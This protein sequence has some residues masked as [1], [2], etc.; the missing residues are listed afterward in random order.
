LEHSY[1]LKICHTRSQR[2]IELNDYVEGRGAAD[3]L[4]RQHEQLA[5]FDIN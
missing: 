4:N 3:V 2:F 5:L 1:R